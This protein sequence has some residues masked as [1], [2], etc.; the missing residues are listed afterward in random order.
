MA[1]VITGGAGFIGSLLAARFAS[2][3]EKALILDNLCRGR[4]EHLAAIER[5][6]TIAFRELDLADEAATLEAMREYI[7]REPVS[8]VWHMAA[9]S[10]IPA[11][12]ADAHV[13]LRDTFLTTFSVLNA[14]RALKIPC[15]AFA[16]SSAIY[17]DLG[18]ETP[19]REDIGPLLPISNYG[20][21]KLASEAL[22]SAA[23]ESWLE[24]ALI[25]RFPNVIGV[26]ATHG[27]ILDFV[28][29]LKKKRGCLHVLGNGSQQKAYLHAESLL[30]AM[31]FIAENAG[32]RINVYNIGPDD[33]GCRVSEIAECVVRAVSPGAAIAY[34]S[35]N[36][37]W[38][39]DVPRFVYSVEKLAALGWRPPASSREAVER[40]VMEIAEQEG[41]ICHRR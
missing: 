18:G 14:M 10:D 35:E 22:I 38:V 19:L 6:G 12:I 40:A 16:S 41:V 15:L 5:E 37:G 36:R 32:A 23:A 8:A 20:A 34:G 31:L 24:R 21:M 39:G 26:P 25:F 17:G 29:K 1:V 7:R 11:G 4:R 28:R 9:N 33:A 27:V 30:D 13:D 2:R 3:G